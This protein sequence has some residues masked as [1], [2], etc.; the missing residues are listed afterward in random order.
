M[1]VVAIWEVNPSSKIWE[2]NLAFKMWE[3]CLFS[4]GDTLPGLIVLWAR[5][6][7]FMS[8]LLLFKGMMWATIDHA[9]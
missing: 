2:V 6:K 7:I 3:V 9:G 4:G 1:A 8:G 5:K